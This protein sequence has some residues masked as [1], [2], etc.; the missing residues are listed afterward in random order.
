LGSSL[1]DRSHG[2]SVVYEAAR[3]LADLG[4][5]ARP[6]A[7]QL[8]VLLQD[9]E[10]MVRCAAVGAVASVQPPEFFDLLVRCAQDEQ[11]VVRMAVIDSVASFVSRGAPVEKPAVVE[12]LIKG[13][14]DKSWV[15]RSSAMNGLGRL[16][17]DA[18]PALPRLRELAASKDPWNRQ[19]AKDAIERIDVR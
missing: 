15:V 14:D 2:Y 1:A 19:A 9:D 6:L 18:R 11:E 17:Q 5:R 7:G 13:L 10:V 12:L 3:A 4:E 8:V 16:G